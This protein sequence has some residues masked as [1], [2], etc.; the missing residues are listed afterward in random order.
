MAT[1]DVLAST[2]P[3]SLAM[4]LDPALIMR[5][6]GL[7]PESWQEAELR[8]RRHRSLWNVTRGGG[9]STTA[10]VLSIDELI[11]GRAL[12]GQTPVVLVIAPAERQALRLLRITKSMMKKLPGAPEPVRSTK[13]EVEFSDGAY[14]AAMPSTENVRSIQGVTLLLWEEMSRFMED[15]DGATPAVDATTPMLHEHG[16]ICG[17]STPAGM[18]GAFWRLFTETKRFPEWHRVTITGEDSERISARKLSENRNRMLPNV[19]E[20]E[21]M[22]SFNDSGSQIFRTEMIRAALSG[23]VEALAVPW[24]RFA[25]TSGVTI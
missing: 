21:F 22:C 1:A 24:V 20:S 19:Y 6:V 7:G 9:K 17:I 18:R 12:H 16:R 13:S 10:C 11:N 8:A 23:D 2:T 4:A 15:A 25:R 14:M 5:R 3:A